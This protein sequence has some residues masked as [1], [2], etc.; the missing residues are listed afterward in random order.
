MNNNWYKYELQRLEEDQKFLK[1]I[2]LGIAVFGAVFIDLWT[3]YSTNY[4]LDMMTSHPYPERMVI[5]IGI[6]IG[7]AIVIN[8][9]TMMMYFSMR[10][11]DKSKTNCEEC[12]KEIFIFGDDPKAIC[13]LCQMRST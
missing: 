3:V 7:S 10:K 4:H 5:L 9:L 11:K 1:R 8:V 2:T 12:G 13:P 6:F